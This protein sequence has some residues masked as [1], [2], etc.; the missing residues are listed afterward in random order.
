MANVDSAFGLRPVRHSGGGTIRTSEYRIASTYGTSIFTGDP[1]LTSGTGKEINIGGAGGNIVGVFAGCEYQTAAGVFFSKY[2]PLSTILLA[3][4]VCKAY[5]YDDPSI[6]FAVQVATDGTGITAAMIG[7][8]ADLASGTGSTQTGLSAW[9]LTAPGTDAQVRILELNAD[10]G[11]A[12]GE[13]AVVNVLIAEHEL[14]GNL[15]EV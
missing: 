12:Y 7:D 9:E 6:V 4:T 15:T 5:V 11:N 10:P 1:V 2:W 14:A 3:G 8:K 13:H